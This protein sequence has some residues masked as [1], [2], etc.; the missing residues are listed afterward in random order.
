MI[1]KIQDFIANVSQLAINLH[2]WPAYTS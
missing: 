1:T 2:P